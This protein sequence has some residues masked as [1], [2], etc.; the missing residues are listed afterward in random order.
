M[1]PS[2]DALEC[3]RQLQ[4]VTVFPSTLFARCYQRKC[5]RFIAT[6]HK[7]LFLKHTR[8]VD[9]LH[10]S[11]NKDTFVEKSASIGGGLKLNAVRVIKSI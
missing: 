9:F 11:E 7:T 8:L 2:R 4:V 5:R 3:W 6:F 10:T 1:T